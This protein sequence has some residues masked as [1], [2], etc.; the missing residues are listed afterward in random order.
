MTRRTIFALVAV[1]PTLA[2]EMPPPI[3][4]GPIE[5]NDVIYDTT[6]GYD[7]Y[8]SASNYTPAAPAPMAAASSDRKGYVNLNVF[9]TNYEVRG[10]GVKDD[11][12]K[13]GTSSLSASYTL[14]NRNLLGRG[15]QQRISGEYG[16]IWDAGCPL[17]D[18]PAAHFSYAIGKEL[19]PN[20]VAEVGYTFRRGGLEG[21]MARHFDGASHRATQEIVA[22]A[23]AMGMT[24]GAP[25]LANPLNPTHSPSGIMAAASSAVST[26][27]RIAAVYCP[28]Y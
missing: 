18:T 20:M 24:L 22:S 16:I 7:A 1:L 6:Y 15:L 23:I 4:D 8:D 17:G 13:Y 26:L 25:A 28:L 9:S 3:P 10:M 12:S 21:F 5:Y 19:F 27:Y 2:T 11:F 14:P